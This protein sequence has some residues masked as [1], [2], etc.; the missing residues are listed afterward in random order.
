MSDFDVSKDLQNKL[1]EAV[2][3]NPDLM[4]QLLAGGLSSNTPSSHSTTG[5]QSRL[6]QKLTNFSQRPGMQKLSGASAGINAGV[7]ALSALA[8]RNSAIDMSAPTRKAEQ[9]LNMAGDAMS[10]IPFLS[11]FSFIPKIAGAIT[12]GLT[13]HTNKDYIK[14][15][16]NNLSTQNNMVSNANSVEGAIQDLNKIAKMDVGDLKNFGDIGF[17][18]N[19]KN[20]KAARASALNAADIAYN[21][22]FR[23]VSNKIDTLQNSKTMNDYMSITAFGGN[24]GTN[25]SNWSTGL[26]HVDNGS[27]HE[28]NPYEG[29]PMGADSEG[30]PNLVEQNETIYDD[31]VFSNRL[32][33]PAFRGK[34][35]AY[36]KRTMKAE[37]GKIEKANKAKLPTWEER[38][39]KKYGGMSFSKAAKKIEHDTGVDERPND[40]IA[41][42]GM[43]AYLQALRNIQELERAKKDLRSKGDFEGARE[44]N[45][46]SG[47]EFAQMQAEEQARQE[48]E[49]MMQQQAMQEQQL[50]EQQMMAQQQGADPQQQMMDQQQ[51]DPNQ[52][53]MMQQ[54]MMEQQGAPMQASCGGKLNKHDDGGEMQEEQPEQQEDSM[55]KD[56]SEMSDKELNETIED[57]IDWAEQTEDKQLLARAEKAK[58]AKREDK[59]AFVEDAINQIQQEEQAYNQRQQEEAAAQQQQISPEEQAMMQQQAQQQQPSPEEQ[60]MMEQQ[61]QMAMQQAMAAQGGQ[62]MMAYGGYRRFDDGGALEKQQQLASMYYSYLK[63]KSP[64]KYEALQKGMSAYMQQYAAQFQN[65]PSDKQEAAVQ[66][67]QM[68]Y[69]Y[70]A[71][72]KDSEFLSYIQ[73]AKQAQTTQ[74]YAEGGELTDEQMLQQEQQEAQGT[75]EEQSQGPDFLSIEDPAELSTKELNKTIEEILQYAKENK[76]KDLAKAARRVKRSSREEKEDFIEDA[77]DEISEIEEQKAQEAEQEQSQEPSPEEQE[78]MAQ[79]AQAQQQ[80]S[81]E[82]MMQQQ[83]MQEQMMQQQMMQQQGAMPADA[84]DELE[85]QMQAEPSFAYGGRLNNRFDYGGNQRDPYSKWYDWRNARYGKDSWENDPFSRFWTKFDQKDAYIEKE[86]ASPNKLPWGWRKKYDTKDRNAAKQK[87]AE[88]KWENYL[89]G[90][91]ADLPKLLPVEAQGALPLTIDPSKEEDLQYIKDMQVVMHFLN[92]HDNN[93]YNDDLDTLTESQLDIFNALTNKGR[94]SNPN[95]DSALRKR[96]LDTTE[97]VIDR[98]KYDELGI[99]E[100]MNLAIRAGVSDKILDLLDKEIKEDIRTTKG[101]FTFKDKGNSIQ[102]SIRN[103]LFNELDIISRNNP[104]A[105]KSQR[106]TNMEWQGNGRDSY[107]DAE[108]ISVQNGEHPE[109]YYYDVDG[110]GKKVTTPDWIERFDGIYDWGNE[111]YGGSPDVIRSSDDANVY[112][113]QNWKNAEGKIVVGDNTY[114]TIGDYEMSTEYL[115]PRYLLAKAAADNDSTWNSYI[116]SKNLVGEGRYTA[117]ALFGADYMDYLDDYEEFA[118]YIRSNKD[119]LKSSLFFD[120]KAGQMHGIPQLSGNLIRFDDIQNVEGAPIG[121]YYKY[122]P[123]DPY[124]SY[125]YDIVED[126]NKIGSFNTYVARAKQT[127]D[128]YNQAYIDKIADVPSNPAP[129]PG[130]PSVEI[131]PNSIYD[132]DW[133]AQNN[134]EDQGSTITTDVEGANPAVTAVTNGQQP[135]ATVVAGSTGG[136]GNPAQRRI[137]YRYIDPKTGRMRN[138][139]ASAFGTDDADYYFSNFGKGFELSNTTKSDDSSIEYRTYKQIPKAPLPDNLPFYLQMGLGLTGLGWNLWQANKPSRYQN[140]NDLINTAKSSGKYAPVTFRPIGDYVTPNRFNMNYWA[141]QQRANSLATQA[142]IMNANNGNIGSTNS[143]LLANSYNQTLGLGDLARKGQEYNTDLQFKEAEFNRGTNQY[144]SEGFL[145]ADIANQD[146]QIKANSTSM[147][148]LAQG[149]AMKNA[150]DEANGN[151]INASLKN[152]MDGLYNIYSN[153]YT[154]KQV[155]YGAKTG[156]Y[157][158]AKVQGKDGGFLKPRIGLS[159]LIGG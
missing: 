57:I 135:A 148:G 53:A 86:M 78:M 126:D 15:V 17:L 101:P 143:A 111:I 4:Q 69:L 13:D 128:I 7:T 150:V 147:T 62:P 134:P 30:T 97:S 100:I 37:G 51:M 47:E 41:K 38:I 123:N 131:D 119:D 95:F 129:A 124:L 149:Y 54:Q 46:L 136:T 45:K 113:I 63:Q 14:S 68:K 151:A 158:N 43:N 32:I 132:E 73:K 94:N 56:P 18:S 31:Y 8:N 48:Q 28:K 144:N 141:D 116:N 21:T 139:D 112:N 137:V 156:T 6:G 33:V 88:E 103:L 10:Q 35:I 66:Q 60:A 145:K 16:G 22:S 27:T 117:E 83:A 118:N 29:V 157:A 75:Q 90:V 55:E 105:L 120:G 85:S 81:E 77:I 80:P 2:V 19:G 59:I 142:A 96:Y 130:N 11:A 140:A 65:L 39:L 159:H 12:G 109:I 52:Q 108:R 82:E 155:R 61:Q 98:A 20:V 92:N 104:E 40:W 23:N 153:N 70:D 49:A 146:A 152:I 106:P 74:E 34:R 154:N 114:D 125:Y 127:P 93:N 76:I 36:G 3:A 67:L 64:S 84:G 133:D 25:S 24:L 99:D 26:T 121:T 122:N 1:L 91:I 102:D 138:V 42:Q 87:M 44:L 72:S 50:Q 110:N 107:R 5:N 89:K 9:Y 71:A 115:Y 79:Q 58:K